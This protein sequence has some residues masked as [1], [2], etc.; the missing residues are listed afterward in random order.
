MARSELN[1]KQ[2]TDKYYVMLVVY[3]YSADQMV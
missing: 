3:V 1:D 2:S